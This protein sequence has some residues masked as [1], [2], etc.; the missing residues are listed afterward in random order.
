MV[1]WRSA[2]TVQLELGANRVLI[3]NVGPEQLSALLGRSET[4]DRSTAQ[5]G[6]D[7][8]RPVAAPGQ[9][10]DALAAA[11]FLT[12]RPAA[13]QL[14]QAGGPVP[15]QLGPELWALTGR[16]G[17]PAGTLLARRRRSAVAVHG[18]SRIT[19]SI[20]ATLASAGVGWVQLVHGGEVSAGDGCPGGLRPADEG[21]RF[22]VAGVQAVQAAAPGVQTAPIPRNRF[23][24]LVIL[25][26]P[27]PVEP[28]VRASLHLDG[29]AHLSATVAGSHA[30]IG[31]LVLP[32]ASSCLHCADLHRCERDPCWPSL[33]VQLS[34]RPAR[35][36][37]SEVALCVATAGLAVGQA[38]AYLDRQHPE[39]V[40]GTLE[41][42]L[43]DW[44]LRRRSWPPHRDCDCGAAA[45]LVRHGRMSS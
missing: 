14:G 45:H 10:V 27:E 44:R 19:T 41:W 42:Q 21:A 23:A 39:T 13:E 32:G 24:D 31:P 34:A 43:P 22:G 11:G 16:H 7:R 17:D 38:L 18:T 1:L 36:A 40:D 5:A 28:S 9:L 8:S 3:D 2:A 30:V 6:S 20:A 33:A 4:G 15:A 12:S 35:R 26:D 29:L 37:G 25:T